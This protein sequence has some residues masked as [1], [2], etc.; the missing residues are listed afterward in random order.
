MRRLDGISK[1]A[2]G[3]QPDP[4]G[5]ERRKKM[6]EI[7]CSTSG[8]PAK[9]IEKLYTGYRTQHTE[10]IKNIDSIIN[11]YNGSNLATFSLSDK[12]SALCSI[13]NNIYIEIY[14]DIPTEN[15]GT[16]SSFY[17]SCKNLTKERVN[18][19]Y[20]YVKVLMVQKSNQLLDETTKAYTKKNF[21]EEKLMA[22]RNIIAGV[23]DMFQ[24]I[25]K[26]APV[27]KT[28]SK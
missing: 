19:E 13:I 28:C 8:I 17:D 7:A 27:S 12:Y 26:Q 25:V 4:A 20:S 16:V 18:R 2:Y 3:L 15:R 23:K 11:N 14:K 6:D 22:L 10:S 24:T 5:L 21:V 9:E 1:L